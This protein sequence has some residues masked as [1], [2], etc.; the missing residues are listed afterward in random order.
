M[1]PHHVSIALC[2]LGCREKAWRSRS[3]ECAAVGQERRRMS[4]H[5]VRR[6]AKE[7]GGIGRLRYLL[8]ETVIR[9]ALLP[10]QHY[11]LQS[12]SIAEIRTQISTVQPRSGT[13]VGR[14]VEAV[15]EGE[16]NTGGTE[17]SSS[18]GASTKDPL[19]RSR[20]QSF[21]SSHRPSRSR[22]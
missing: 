12:W 21:A 4:R 17:R 1:Q 10:G 20:A 11:L 3:S 8:S 13:A 14:S 5:H 18:I 22:L 9:L 2:I 15:D 19:Y 7:V 16:G 6:R